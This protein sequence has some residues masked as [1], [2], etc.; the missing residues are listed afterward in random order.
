MTPFHPGLPVASR[1]RLAHIG[2]ARLAILYG[3]P[4]AGRSLAV[5][6]GWIERSWRRCL[7]HGQR[8]EQA[9]S[10]SAVAAAEV[11]RTLEA[12]RQ[13]TEAAR[14]V[15]QKLGRAIADTRYFA[16]LTNQNGVVV[17]V[18]GPIDRRDRRADVITRIGADLSE[19]QIGTTAIGAT[20]SELEP[21]WLHRGE[22]FFDATSV[23]SC[24]GAPLF[25]P[26]GN[27]VGMLDL[28]GIET[29]E[30]PELKHL[31]TQSAQSI[32]NA[33]TL[34]RPPCPAHPAQLAGSAAGRGGGRVGVRGRGWLRHRGEPDG[35]SAGAA[36]GP[37]HFFGHAL[38]RPVRHAV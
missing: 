33:L 3:D 14:P 9:P 17:D 5:V 34:S 24:A 27:C 30:R 32:E 11:R 2:R 21:V 37:G 4:E 22:H 18:N 25:G 8:P 28:T 13:L 16:I 12:N 15:L 35:T 20:L 19:R 36:T 7:G 31:V 38:P 1:D 26:D 6:E 23:Y 29:V 10:F